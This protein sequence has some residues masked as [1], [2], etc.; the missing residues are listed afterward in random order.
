MST[1]TASRLDKIYRRMLITRFFE[2]GW[3]KAENLRRLFEFRKFVSNRDTCYNLI[4]RD[5][6]V[7][8]TREEKT[9]ECLL[10]DGEFLSPMELFLPGVVPPESRKSNFQL[11]LPLKWK[12]E[13]YKPVC[14]HFAGTGDHFFWR[15]RNFMAKP[16]LREGGIGAILLENPFYGLRKPKDQVRSNLQHVSDIFVM[17]G[18]L[19]LESLVL[20]HF[21]ERNG[22]GP[23]GVSGLSMGGHMASL[24]ATNWPK[25]LVVVPCLSWS[26]AAA[27]FT[28]GVMSE[29][30]NWSELENQFFSSSVFRKKLAKM[31]NVVDGWD[32]AFMAG[33]RFVQNYDNTNSNLDN[34]L[35]TIANNI[36]YQSDTPVSTA[37]CTS[38]KIS[39]IYRQIEELNNNSHESTIEEDN[40]IDIM[41]RLKLE[42]I[43]TTKI[44]WW[45]RE[46]LQFMRG[47]MDE[48]THLKNFSVP[49]DTSL[50]TAVCA[51]DDAYV[52]REGTSS[53]E[54]IWP[55]AEVKYIDAGHVSAYVLY[56]KLIRSS[57][58]DKFEKAKEKYQYYTNPIPP[59]TTMDTLQKRWRSSITIEAIQSVPNQ[60]NLIEDEANKLASSNT[61]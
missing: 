40:V 52:P 51:K 17:G 36:S 29:S 3:G 4:P 42:P 39:E 27:V 38:D 12:N 50:I 19:I 54:D 25:P 37:N 30:I 21:C 23:L 59:D 9:S 14:V 22:L 26:T 53:L 11:V 41:A 43:D 1:A 6:P 58:I 8:I 33:R 2:K 48:C 7:Q 31:V 45:E 56:Q 24:A 20:F 49:Y 60:E 28:Q 44:K 10:I 57:I 15:R 5:Y 34:D 61:N 32:E 16:L 55:G 46:A 47:M 35:K 18:C 13:K